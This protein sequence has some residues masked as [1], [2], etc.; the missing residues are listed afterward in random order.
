[1]F[2][3]KMVIMRDHFCLQSIQNKKK[4]L[5]ELCVKIKYKRTHTPCESFSCRVFQKCSGTTLVCNWLRCNWT[6]RSNLSTPFIIEIWLRK[7]NILIPLSPHDKLLL[8]ILIY[9][10]SI[11]KDLPQFAFSCRDDVIGAIFCMKSRISSIAWFCTKIC[12]KIGNQPKF[13]VF[14]GQIFVQ[15]HAKLHHTKICPSLHFS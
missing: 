11:Y 6:K 3:L 5:R 9:L 12:P 13:R 4:I 14:D 2:M 10:V 15:W 8:L 7:D 1:M